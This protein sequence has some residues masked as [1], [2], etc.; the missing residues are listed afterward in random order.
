[1]PQAPG[2]LSV[3]SPF[4][5]PALP[6][7]FGGVMLRYTFAD[8]VELHLFA[9]ELFRPEITLLLEAAVRIHGKATVTEPRPG[10]FV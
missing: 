10:R 5:N 1:M 2:S 3:V 9:H 7:I 6:A 4:K 8:G